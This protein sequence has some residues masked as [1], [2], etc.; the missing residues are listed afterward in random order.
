MGTMVVVLNNGMDRLEN[1]GFVGTQRSKESTALK[2][3]WDKVIFRSVRLY[4]GKWKADVSHH[5]RSPPLFWN[6]IIER[7]GH[8]AP[9]W[10]GVE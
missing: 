2:F 8:R 3:C 9:I 6:E 4:S 1:S 5:N 7:R 10:K